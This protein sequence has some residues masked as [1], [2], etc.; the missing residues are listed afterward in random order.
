MNNDHIKVV[1]EGLSQIPSDGLQRLIDHIDE[2]KPVLLDGSVTSMIGNSV[3][4]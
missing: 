1:Y 3:L 2:G 4:L